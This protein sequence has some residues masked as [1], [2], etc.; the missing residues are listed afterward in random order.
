MKLGL[1]VLPANAPGAMRADAKAEDKPMEVTVVELKKDKVV[2]AWN[3][4]T[5]PI[6]SMN[7]TARK[8]ES[9]RLPKKPLHCSFD[10]G[11]IEGSA[12]KHGVLVGTS[13]RDAPLSA[14][15]QIP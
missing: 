7:H 4:R 15:K 2:A 12:R 11:M 5:P 3:R 1:L 6:P 14:T 8:S 13:A 9:T 10:A